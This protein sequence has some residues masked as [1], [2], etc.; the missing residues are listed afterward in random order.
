MLTQW[1]SGDVVANGIKLHYLLWAKE[2]PFA[3]WR[4]TVPRLACPVLLITA[5]PALGGIVSPEVA[6][7]VANLNPRVKVAHVKMAGH[8]IRREQ[9]AAYL[10]AVTVFLRGVTGL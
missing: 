3:S 10:Q 2:A 5:D 4:E 1:A 8:S 7:Q 6:Q 9:F